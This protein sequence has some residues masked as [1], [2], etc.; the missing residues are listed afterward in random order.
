MVNMKQDPKDTEEKGTMLTPAEP[1]EAAYPYGLMLCLESEQL[2]KLGITELPAVGAKMRISA[3]AEV[4]GIG[5]NQEM[6]GEVC[7]NVRLQITDMDPPAPATM[8]M[9][10]RLYKGPG[11]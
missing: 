1:E 6:G 7:R 3:M 5:Q 2:D 10:K 8:P 4:V 9:E 11:G